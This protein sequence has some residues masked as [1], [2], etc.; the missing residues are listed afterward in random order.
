MK[1]A[2]RT[3]YTITELMPR[4]R[5][6]IRHAWSSINPYL[7]RIFFSFIFPSIQFFFH[8]IICILPHYMDIRAGSISYCDKGIPSNFHCTALHSYFTYSINLSYV[9]AL[10]F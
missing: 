7:A 9:P 5:P 4:A 1:R 10:F 2:Y 6:L 3:S 8:C